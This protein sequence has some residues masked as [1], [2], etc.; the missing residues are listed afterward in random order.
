MR[1]RAIS[2]VHFIDNYK[3]EFNFMVFKHTIR[4]NIYAMK[5]PKNTTLKTWYR[6]RNIYQLSSARFFFFK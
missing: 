2:T 1:L 3:Y 5:T 4:K 6:P